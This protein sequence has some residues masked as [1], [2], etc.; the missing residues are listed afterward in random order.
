M[1]KL[2]LPFPYLILIITIFIAAIGIF[3]C[4]KYRSIDSYG[5]YVECDEGFLKI[6]VLES[7]YTGNFAGNPTEISNPTQFI[8]YYDGV[9]PAQLD[10]KSL[11]I[12]DDPSEYWYVIS[13]GVTTPSVPFNIEPVKNRKNIY[14]LK[15]NTKLKPGVYCV[16]GIYQGPFGTINDKAPC[17]EVTE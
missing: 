8:V 14:S 3:S 6:N 2:T 9:S 17:F 12:F 5:T 4:S 10:I 15:P 16:L 7:S 1:K 13:S 11:R